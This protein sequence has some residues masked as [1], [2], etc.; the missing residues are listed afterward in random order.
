MRRITIVSLLMAALLMLVWSVADA[1]PKK[2]S[3][4]HAQTFADL[5]DEIL[6][7]L[8]TFYPVTATEMGVHTFDH[9]LT[10]YSAKSVKEMINRLKQY[11]SRLGKLRN[12]AF[13]PADLLNYKLI[14]SNVDVALLNLDKIAWYRRSPQ[15]Y[16]DEAINGIYFLLLSNH[17]TPAG[18]L[19]ALL[20]RMRQVPS[21]FATAKAQIHTPPKVYVQTAKAS[22]ETGLEFYRQV[23]SDL[24]QQFPSRA[25]SILDISTTAR[26]AM[27]EFLEYLDAV[28]VGGEKSFAIGEAN[29]NYLLQY[30]HFLPFTAD[31]LLRLGEA[32]LA[33][34]DK[35]YT[36]Y[37][38]T[39]EKNHQTGQDSV[40]IPATFTR[41]DILDYYQWEVDQ[42]RKFLS[43]NHVLSIP[44]DIAPV[45][46]VET[47]PMLR[48]MVSGIAYQPAGPFDSQ[49]VGYF[50][51]RP[52]PDSM[53]QAQLDAR[54]RFV[55]RRGFRGSV[56]HEAY[57]GHHLQM[58][59]AGRNTSPVRK[60][61]RNLLMIEGWALY[62]EEMMYKTGLFG[63]ENPP[64]WLAILG[65][66]RFRAARIVADVK[67]HTGQWSYDECV[68]W[69]IRTLNINTESQE[70]YI[71][72]EVLRY[73]HAPTVQMSYLIGK[74]EIERLRD[75]VQARD[76]ANFSEQAFYDKML[77]EGSIPPALLWDLWRLT[78]SVRQTS[79]R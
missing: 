26:E 35:A 38:S 50:Y 75:A 31:S 14:K 3:R 58:Q 9:R 20:D 13:E 53:D 24:M 43:M 4:S 34:A 54:Y 74:R 56:V 63:L 25:D 27:N 72:K 6:K 16:V 12:N 10:D 70:E 42:V 48:T 5:S 18:K 60:W 23:A 68:D 49:Q 44:D 2:T 36:A 32:L 61:Q 66:I 15:L 67:L 46:V 55:Y 76:G 57:P 22:L 11:E 69:M 30:E 21:L 19:P 17:D 39:V 33:E 8:Q 64:Q 29:F 52:L 7:G 1:A 73:T 47:P 51:V 79:M 71:R 37:E 28:E 41:H 77:A 40:F 59:L 62:S 78:P 45:K 65:G